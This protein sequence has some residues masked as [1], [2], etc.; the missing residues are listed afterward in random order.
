MVLCSSIGYVFRVRCLVKHRD[1]FTYIKMRLY[2]LNKSLKLHR[3][4]ICTKCINGE[5]WPFPHV[6]SRKLI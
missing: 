6:L 3:E 5:V 2:T 4:V 1:S